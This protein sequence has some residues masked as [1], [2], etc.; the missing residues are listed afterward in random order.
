MVFVFGAI[1]FV[2]EHIF[3]PQTRHNYILRM[4]HPLKTFWVQ[5]LYFFIAQHKAF[6]KCDELQ[7]KQINRF[8]IGLNKLLVL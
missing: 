8:D 5:F 1:I 7:T 6:T 2:K 4:I 3:T